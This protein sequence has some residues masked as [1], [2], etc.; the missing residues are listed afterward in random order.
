MQEKRKKILEA[1]LDEFSEVGFINSSS[2]SIA[3][4]AEL[5][6]AV[7]RALFVDKKNLLTELFREETE[8]MVNAIGLAVQE[9]EDPKKLIRKA[10]KHLDLWFLMHPKHVKMYMRCVLDGSDVFES[11]YRL[12][13]PSEFFDRLN[14]MIEKGQVRSEDLFILSLLLDSLILFFHMMM[15]G[16]PPISPDESMEE[17]AKLR[18]EAVMDLLENGLYST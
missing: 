13:I 16:L 9:I 14:Q 1:A 4:R 12:L 6:P 11:V 5:E 15:P 2:E 17:I 7:V 10:M 8:P 3:A 18:F